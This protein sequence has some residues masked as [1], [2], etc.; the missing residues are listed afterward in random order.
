MI[1]NAQFKYIFLSYNDEGL[2]NLD[3]IKEIFERYGKYERKEQPYQRFKA[4]S[5]RI[6]KQDFTTEYLHI[7]E[8]DL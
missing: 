7:L 5:K 6:Q 2:L 1:K 8:K 3:E 4:D